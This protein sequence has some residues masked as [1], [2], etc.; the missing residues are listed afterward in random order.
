MRSKL[1]R[2]AA[3]AATAL[4]ATLFAPVGAQ[5]TQTAATPP[6]ATP[7]AVTAGPAAAEAGAAE[8]EAAQVEVATIADEVEVASA[9]YEEVEARLDAQ[10]AR[11][12]S[13]EAH[14]ASQTELIAAMEVELGALAVESFK[15][16]GVDP[17]LSALVDGAGDL[18]SSASTLEVLGDRQ[19]LSLT[20]VKDAKLELERVRALAARELDEVAVL[21]ADLAERR[22]AIEARLAGAKDVLALAEA[23]EQARIAAEAAAEA[24][25]QRVEAERQRV[26]A[27]RSD[28]DAAAADAAAAPDAAAAV[29]AVP[30]GN[31]GLQTPVEGRNSS[32]YGN[33]THP[34]TGAQKLHGGTD[35]ANSCGTPVVAAEDGFVESAK[36][37]GSYGNI[38][39]ITHPD[40]GLSTAYAHLEA[41]A[42]T[43][44]PVAR[45][46]VVGYIG[47]TGMSTG[48]HLHFEV[49]TGGE[50]VDPIPYL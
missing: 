47:T 39:V 22:A 38:I 4:A 37:N 28:R 34:I 7:P 36:W 9:A 45:G 6:A 26:E 17:S 8:I 25:R 16:G 20:E 24:E 3:L 12:A 31:G 40:A 42:V 35:I 43:S 32:P 29:A 10:R 30:A 49:R 46:E 18:S 2:S 33:R 1:P 13:A 41:F 19:S 14:V 23:A 5:A 27:S 21:E 50:Q 48:C 11:V 15:R 44:G